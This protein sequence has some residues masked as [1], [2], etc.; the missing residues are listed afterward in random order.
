[1]KVISNGCNYVWPLK[2]KIAIAKSEE[3]IQEISSKIIGKREFERLR[4]N[5]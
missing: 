4:C 2:V 1:M 5:T 3:G